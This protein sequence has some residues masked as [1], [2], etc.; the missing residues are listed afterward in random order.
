MI[1]RRGLFSRHARIWFIPQPI[2]VLILFFSIEVYLERISG[3][4]W[5][6]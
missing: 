6:A 2:V 1:Y 3:W 5:S 4:F